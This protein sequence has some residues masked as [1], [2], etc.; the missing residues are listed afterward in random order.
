MHACVYNPFAYYT[1]QVIMKVSGR[2][3]ERWLRS[4]MHDMH[5]NNRKE[6]LC[7]CQRCKGGVWLDPF[8]EGRLKAHLLMTGFM[9]GYT[10]WISEDDDDDD[11]DGAA[12]DDM[13]PDEEMTDNGGGEE[14]GHGGREEAGHGGG[15]DRVPS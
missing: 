11:V 10:R 14:A 3:V 12:N 8:K 15:E 5:E 9:D 2:M 13:G 1:A 4:A 7:P 6:I